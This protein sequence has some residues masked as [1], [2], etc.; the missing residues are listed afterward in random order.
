MVPEGWV[1]VKLGEFLSFKNG[2]NASKDAYGSGTKFVNVMDVFGTDRLSESLIIGEMV[3]TE[4]QLQDYSV[5][6][7]DILFNRT[8]ETQDE[9]ALTTVYL[10]HKPVVFGGFVIR[11]RQTMKRL[12]PEF[13]VYAFQSQNVRREMI[14]RGQGVV[15]ANIGQ[16]D[17][18]KVPILVPPKAEQKKIAKILANI[19]RAIETTERLIANSKCQKNA[20]VQQLLTGKKRLPQFK[21]DW[22]PTSLGELLKEVPKEK[23]SNPEDFELLTVKLHTKG[24]ARTGKSPKPTKSGRPYYRRE[25]GELIVGRQNLHNGGIGLAG[26]DVH[27]CIAS[28][29]ISSFRIQKANAHF[30]LEAMSTRKFFHIVDSRVGGTGQKEISARELKKIKLLLPDLPE[31]EAIAEILCAAS[32]EIR[33]QRAKC[34]ELKRERLALMQQ[35]LT[36]KRRVKIDKE[37]AA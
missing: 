27:G 25:K 17:L 19:D 1:E 37:I 24:L 15:R 35:L 14:R 30:I 21:S 13:S 34:R 28:N 7:G 20:L 4:K 29:A 16:K 26:D 18:V 5:V 23:V 32:D 8:S 2:V 11:G 10:D 12:L 9:I 31:Q 6:Y 36:G 3:V 22:K 33:K